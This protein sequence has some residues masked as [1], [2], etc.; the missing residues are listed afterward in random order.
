MS[1]LI[2]AVNMNNIDEVEILLE[3]GMNPNID[4]DEDGETALMRAVSNEYYDIASFLLSYG[5]DP[6]IQENTGQTALII[7]SSYELYEIVVLLLDND[8]D[9]DIIDNT[10]YS[11]L[12]Y[13]IEGEYTSIVFDLLLN[14]ADPNIVTLNQITPL[15]RAS[16][17]GNS[18]IVKILLDNGAE[19]NSRDNRGRTALIMGSGFMDIVELLLSGGAN[20]NYRDNDGNTA[21]SIAEEDGHTEIAELLRR[22]MI[23]RIQS[24]I[25]GKRT[26]R[27]IRGKQ[28]AEQTLSLTK[29]LDD[30]SSTYSKHSRYVPGI[31]EIISKHLSE[32]PYNPEVARRMREEE[33]IEREHLD[34]LQSFSQYGGGKKP[35]IPSKKIIRTIKRP[36]Y[37]ISKR[38]LANT[39]KFHKYAPSFYKN[40]Y[41]RREQIW[42]DEAFKGMLNYYN[43]ILEDQG[44]EVLYLPKGFKIYH[45]SLHYPMPLVENRSGL[46]KMGKG[47]HT[48]FGLD[49]NISIWY[50]LELFQGIYKSID[51]LLSEPRIGYL[52]EFVLTYDLPIYHIIKNIQEHPSEIDQCNEPYTVCLHPQFAYRGYLGLDDD[53]I[54]DFSSELTFNYGYYKD[55]MRI[56]NTYEI[57]ATLLYE[58]KS[59]VNWNIENAIIDK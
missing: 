27:K 58:N 59:D 36:N 30:P 55:Y 26:R 32:I 50:I 48:F 33:E 39:R 25:R 20:P 34:W 22:N 42:E 56:N 24:K 14:G 51:E 28:Q 38:T 12:L 37:T 2:N 8:A 43:T 19:P 45:G 13:A 35:P 44:D 15:M 47:S 16:R 41:M 6:D 11:A 5:A 46:E 3:N 21:L 52:Y 17:L 53:E 49:S 10:D 40:W 31:T 7:A 4:R 23:T 54:K 57:D 29:G 18:D 1:E 9:P